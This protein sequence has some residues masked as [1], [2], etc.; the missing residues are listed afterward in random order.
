MITKAG[1]LRFGKTEVTVVKVLV[2]RLCYYEGTSFHL[3]STQPKVLSSFS[4][5]GMKA[6]ECT[7]GKF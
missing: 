6:N 3:Y 5:L 2:K 4:T 7:S 1:F